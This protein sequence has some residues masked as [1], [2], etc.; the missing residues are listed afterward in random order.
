ME[1][2]CSCGAR[3]CTPGE[4][5]TRA[6][7]MGV[8]HAPHAELPAEER[9]R[10]VHR[11]PRASQLIHRKITAAGLRHG[12][13]CDD[14]RDSRGSCAVNI[15]GCKDCPKNWR[16]S[17]IRS[18]QTREY[19]MSHLDCIANRQRRSRLRDA[20]FAVLVALGAVVSV[21]TVSAAADA[22]S[23]RIASR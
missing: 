18:P 3:S 15:T 2:G 22:A 14:R 17:C 10:R 12:Q 20:V 9:W 5:V 21:S 6:R 1:Q 8:A 23:T 7:L 11:I 13:G 16:L 19:P 4:E